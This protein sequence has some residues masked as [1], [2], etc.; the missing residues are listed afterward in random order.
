[1]CDAAGRPG[2]SFPPVRQRRR[3][4]RHERMTMPKK[5]LAAVLVFAALGPGVLCAQGTLIY[6]ELQ[7]VGAYATETRDFELFSLTPDE[8][9]Q[10]PSLGFDLVRRFSGKTRDIGVLA[11]QARLAYDQEG[12]SK[13]EPQIYNA[14]FRLKTRT[15]S[16]WAGHSRPALGIS[17]VL[18]SHAL[19]LPAPPMMGYGFDRDW[20]IGMERDFPSGSLAVSIS[21][22]HGATLPENR[23]SCG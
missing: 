18:D 12:S 19:I 13:I 10:K 23:C 16:F 22:V 1:M 2:G 5:L 20:G 14:Y 4:A 3:A 7:A 15:F 9:M 21:M 11:V 17:S 8:I 6:L